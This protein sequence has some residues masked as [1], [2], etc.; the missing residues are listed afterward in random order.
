M[1]HLNS[2]TLFMITSP[3]TPFKL[4]KEIDLLTSNF[5][6]YE[7]NNDTQIKYMSLLR[8][9]D[10]F[11]GEGVRDPA[12]SA[13]DR[14][15]RGP[16]ALGFVDLS[17]KVALTDAGKNLLNSRHTEEIFLRQLLKFQLPS[18]YHSLSKHS[19]D[20]WVKPY[21]ELFRLINYFGSLAFDEL[22]LFGM[23]L[24]D[25]RKFDLIVEKIN[26]F[27]KDKANNN[28]SYKTFR[29]DYLRN[30]CSEIY[31]DDIASGNTRIRENN[32]NSISNFLLTKGNNM[33]D[34]ADACCRYLR[35]T[36][37]VNVTRVGKSLSII[38]EKKDE[39]EY[40]LSNISRDP[41]FVNSEDEY[42]DYL[43]DS[44][45]PKL[46][47]DDRR[48]VIN[49][50]RSTFKYT[51]VKNKSLIELKD[52]L[53]DLTWQRRDKLVEQQVENIKNRNE[54]DDINKVFH[55]IS[56]KTIYDLP[57]FFEWNVWRSM[58]M[59]DAGKI[60]ANLKFDD[61][62]M[63]LSTATGNLADIECDYG[64]FGLT[65]EVTLQSGAKQFESEG[66]SIM[67]HLVRYKQKINKD[68]YCFFIA[69]KI[70]E[71]CIQYF[72]QLYTFDL[73]LYCGKSEILPIKLPVFIKMLEDSYKAKYIP[74]SNNILKLCK[75]SKSLIVDQKVEPEEWFNQ[76]NNQAL[77]WLN[78]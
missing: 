17:P 14:I 77:N 60:K 28:K 34:Y 13:R 7:W 74:N 15:N 27:R 41:V 54:Y 39:V 52:I 24:T 62:G 75:F 44:N 23:Q 5:E 48:L 37:M 65:V 40:F 61:Q 67:R 20:F 1:P 55:D 72:Y 9:K 21:L 4:I 63:P 78:I 35:A 56:N 38:P 71:N 64:N 58:T 18:P 53:I 36:G 6:G 45:I 29:G 73:S 57:L 47:S 70:N 68:A 2:K 33:R 51:D 69:P 26:K 49:K 66:E 19:C 3:R 46:L 25:Y 31:A 32:T 22:W 76:L 43:F 59:L 12:L 8:N 50:L 10:F 30:E 11:E 42:K 16:K